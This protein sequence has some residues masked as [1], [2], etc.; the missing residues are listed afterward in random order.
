MNFRLWF[1]CLTLP[2]LQACSPSAPPKE[3]V[4][5]VKLISVQTDDALTST[6][7]AAEV[8]ARQEARLSFRIPGQL[9]HRHVGLGQRFKAG[10]ILAELDP[11]D[12]GLGLQAAQAQLAAAKVQRD[13]AA[14]EWRRFEALFQQGF[15]GPAEM[16][17]RKTAMQAAQAQ[18]DQAQAQAELQLNQSRYTRLTPQQA[19]VVTAIEAEPG[20]VLAAGTPVLRVAWDGPRE[21][22]VWVAED[23]LTL[24]QAGQVVEV[25]RWGESARVQARVREVS[26]SADPVTRSFLVRIDLPGQLDWALGQTARVWQV[27]KKIKSAEVMLPTSAVVQSQGQAQVWVF[28]PQQRS[29]QP[30]PVEVLRYQGDQVVIGSGLQTGQQVVVMGGHTLSPGQVVTPFVGKNPAPQPADGDSGARP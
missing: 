1:Y 18:L 27:G 10:Q 17:R 21:V 22:Q 2:L 7:W 4:R 30:V 20:Q 5:S 26:A 8:R 6:G 9:T 3:P 11:Q 23:Q 13:L 25:T 29:V 16:D 15:I 14:S 24:W 19:G 12:Q 28:D